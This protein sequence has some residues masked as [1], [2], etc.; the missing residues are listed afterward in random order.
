MHRAIA[1]W[2]TA[3]PWRA[4]M[5]SAF[6]GALSPQMLMPFMVLA[7]AIPVLAVLRSNAGLGLAMAAIGAFSATWVVLS[8]SQAAQWVLAGIVGLFFS[9]VLLGVLLKRTGSLNLCFQVAVLA[10]SAGLVVVHLLLPDPAGVWHELLRKVLDSM[11]AAGIKV[12]GDTGALIEIWA[13]T[14]WG[15]LAALT[16]ALVLGSLFLGC[17]WQSLVAA[18]G[19]FGA[20]YR[21]LRLGRV[22]GLCITV[23]FATAFFVE[24]ALLASLAWVAFAALSFQGLAAAHS[25]K[26]RGQLNRGWLAAIYVLLIVPLSTSVT[27]LALAIWGFADNWLR[28]RPLRA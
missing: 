26:A 25:S 28:P 10:A 5:A 17:W 22:L 18:P 4:A 15:A 23:L 9:P 20:E 11:A 6:C 13:R 21:Q 14:M 8:L 19:R 24:S 12:E 27:V 1:E 16:L 7:G 3:R 2:L